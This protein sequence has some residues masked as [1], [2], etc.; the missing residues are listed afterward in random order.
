MKKITYCNTIERSMLLL[1]DML[2]DR[3]EDS[4]KEDLSAEQII[5]IVQ[6]IKTLCEIDSNL[7]QAKNGKVYVINVSED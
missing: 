1:T 2:Y 6:G 4:S 5:A 3:K 7:Y